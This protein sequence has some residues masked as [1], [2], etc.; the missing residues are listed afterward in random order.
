MLKRLSRMGKMGLLSSRGSAA[1]VYR[2][3]VVLQLGPIRFN[4][5][6]LQCQAHPVDGGGALFGR[7]R[8]CFSSH[9]DGNCML[10]NIRRVTS[11]RVFIFHIMQG[12]ICWINREF[13][14]FYR[15]WHFWTH[16]HNLK[17]QIMLSNL[18]Y[19]YF[20]LTLFWSYKIYTPVT[21]KA[22]FT[23]LASC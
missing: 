20:L 5:T 9:V 23:I 3:R 10:C 8:P 17:L 12:K 14:A 15:K 16:F 11:G 18:V 13:R 19:I 1:P 4:G 7:K 6:D 22:A 2:L 21:S